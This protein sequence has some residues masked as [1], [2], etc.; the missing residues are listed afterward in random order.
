[1]NNSLTEVKGTAYVYNVYIGHYTM[2]LTGLS[3]SGSTIK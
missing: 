2:M 3:N 1:M